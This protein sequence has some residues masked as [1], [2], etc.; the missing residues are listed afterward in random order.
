MARYQS[1]DGT[2]YNFTGSFLGLCLLILIGIV[3]VPM[4]GC[5]KYKVYTAHMDGAAEYAQA[6]ANRK[7]LVQTAEA[8]AEAAAF[9][10]Q[11]KITEAQGV[12][13]SNKIIG[14]S[15]ANNPD[16]LTYIWLKGLQDHDNNVIYVATEA[17]IPITEGQRLNAFRRIE[18]HSV[19]RELKGD[20]IHED[21]QHA[22][23][24]KE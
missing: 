21:K 7:I 9:E 4:V 19:E 8:R 23:P 11:A 17:G 6:E 20:H 5:P 15:L 3:A 14:D 16:Y 12:A 18:K 24:V 1:N 10:K 13:E 22:S 2:V